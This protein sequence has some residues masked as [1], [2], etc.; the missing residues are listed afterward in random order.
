MLVYVVSKMFSDSNVMNHNAK[1][2]FEFLFPEL[3]YSFLE[4]PKVYIS[5]CKLFKL[6]KIEICGIDYFV[7]FVWPLKEVCD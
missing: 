5:E 7:Q 1:N 2:R 4:F 3:S 6:C